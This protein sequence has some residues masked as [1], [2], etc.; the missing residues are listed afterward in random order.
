VVG[1]RYSA[2]DECARLGSVD[3][4]VINAAPGGLS[5][6]GIAVRV[7][8]GG[9]PVLFTLYINRFNNRKNNNS[10]SF[11]QHPPIIKFS[12]SMKISCDGFANPN[13]IL[14]KH[15]MSKK[16]DRFTEAFYQYYPL[17]F[18]S[19][20]TKV[21]N[22]DDTEDIC[23][24]V[25]IRFYNKMEEI[26]NIKHWLYGALRLV[27]LEHYRKRTD[28]HINIDEVFFDI[29]LTFVN[30]MRES[31]IIISEAMETLDERMDDEERVIF[32]LVAVFNYS[33]SETARHLGMTKRMVEYRYRRIVDRILAYLKTR[34]IRELDELL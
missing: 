25:F 10:R 4:S 17:V 21:D 2:R 26:Q 24:E 15:P 22:L 23:Q 32:E 11:K 34:G 8:H 20:Y 30:G 3:F 5:A 28:D 16:R 6:C 33:Y 1:A 27:V 7:L 9:T 31:R 29:G 18:S 12:T 13:T 19:V 14:I